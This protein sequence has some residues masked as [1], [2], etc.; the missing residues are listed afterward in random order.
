M[1]STPP[2]KDEQKECDDLQ[3]FRPVRKPRPGDGLLFVR[4]ELTPL[5]S[6]LE[7]TH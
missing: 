7:Q 5:R 1:L 2:I 3:G 6:L 4:P